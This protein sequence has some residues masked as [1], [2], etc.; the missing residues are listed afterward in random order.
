MKFGLKQLHINAINCIFSQYPEIVMV[1]I[2]GSRAKGTFR[3]GSDIDLTLIENKLTFSQLMEIENKID[4]LLLPYKID[5]SQKR[6]IS[7]PELINHI[8]R[9]GLEFYRRENG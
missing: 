9:C 6:K 1:I 4:D 7:D 2:Y 5:L 8:N 3:K